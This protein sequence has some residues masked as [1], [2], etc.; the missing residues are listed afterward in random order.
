MKP[1]NS[2]GYITLL[3]MF[4]NFL[5]LVSAS[6]I[7]TRSNPDTTTVSGL[8]F[9]SVYPSQGRVLVSDAF[10]LVITD[11]CIS[12]T[13]QTRL[14]MMATTFINISVQNAKGGLNFRITKLW[15]TVVQYSNFSD[16]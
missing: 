9:S 7:Q 5:A 1:L 8:F 13:G 11:K 3:K 10:F 12:I 4:Y 16:I 14:E 2:K 15:E 6:F